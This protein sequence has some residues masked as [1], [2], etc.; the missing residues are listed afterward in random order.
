M[1]CEILS[2]IWYLLP[3]HLIIA[4]EPS[5][6]KNYLVRWHMLHYIWFLCKGSPTNNTLEWSLPSMWSQ[7]LLQI[8]FLL[9][10]LLTVHTFHLKFKIGLVLP[11]YKL[12]GIFRINICINCYLIVKFFS[13]NF[14]FLFHQGRLFI[15]IDQG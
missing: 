14:F 3:T 7:M 11:N 9:E 1:N 4:F 13:Y 5:R 15:F 12:N 8:K 10:F 2:K 6:L